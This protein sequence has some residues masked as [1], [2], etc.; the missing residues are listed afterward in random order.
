MADD[1]AFLVHFSRTLCISLPRVGASVTALKEQLQAREGVP[2]ALVELYADGRR[3]A[4]D[5]HVPRLPALVRARLSG[6]LRGGKGGFGAMLRSSGK[7]AGAKATTSFGACRDLNGRRLRHV[8]Q[9]VAVQKWRD[10]AEARAQRRKLG[11]SDQEVLDDETPS[12]IPGWYLA[13]PSWAEGAKKSYMKRRRN[14]VLCKHWQQARADGRA[15]PPPRAPRWWGCPRGRDCDYAHGEEE[16]RGAGLTELK[17]A[18]K[19]AAQQTKQQGLAGY[20]DYEREIPDDV[21]EAVRQGLRQRRRAQSKKLEPAALEP[22]WLAPLGG[23]VGTAFKHGLCELRGQSNFGTA[24]ASAC[25]V[26]AGQ[27]YYEVRLVTAGVAQLGWADGS[28]AADSAAGDG[29]GDHARSWAYDGSRQLKWSAGRES[30]FGGGA[31]WTKG[32]VIGCLLDLDAGTIAF[33]RNGGALGVAFEGVRCLEDEDEDDDDVAVAA[34]ASAKQCGFFPAISVEQAEI[35]LVNLGAQPFAFQEVGYRAVWDA[36]S[37]GAERDAN[38]SQAAEPAAPAEPP[39]AAAAVEHNEPVASQKATQEAK[40]SYIPIEL[41]AYESVDELA[42]LGLDALK[43]ELQHRGLK[44]GGSLVERAERLLS[45]RG[46][47]WDEIAAK[48][49]DPKAGARKAN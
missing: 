29:V 11:V 42:K 21:A 2:A 47:S 18:K 17:R 45:V 27:W 13:T 44:C 23:A 3:L 34:A 30:A 16:L 4:A 35:V 24:T 48:L 39:A 32:D 28:F 9:E 7:G 33:S 49:K 8:N 10:D 36:L 31:A 12:G 43:Q 25:R 37:A 14:T 15:P 6:G 40:A 20:V 26:T 38:L 22:A 41:S 1:D 46:K 5:A 19:E